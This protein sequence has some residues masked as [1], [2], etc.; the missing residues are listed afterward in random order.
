MAELTP[1]PAAATGRPAC[2]G[3]PCPSRGER[4][5]VAD[6]AM[7]FEAEPRPA[8]DA[9]LFQALLE[10]IAEVEAR[11]YRLL[12]RLGA[13]TLRSVRT[14]GGGAANPAWTA[15]RARL[16]QV[17]MPPAVS[18][19]PAYGTALLARRG[20]TAAMKPEHC[21]ELAAFSAAIGRDA[22]QVQAAG[23]NTS[24]KADGLLVGQGVG[25]VARRCAARRTSSCRSGWA[26]CWR[27]S[28]PVPPIRSPR[29]WRPSSTRRACARRSRPRCTRCCRT[30]RRAHPLGPDDRPGD[31]R[32][33][34]G[35]DRRAA[36]RPALALGALPKPGLPLTRAVADRLGT[37]RST[38]SCWAIMASSSVAHRWPRRQ[39]LLAEV[40][41]RLDAPSD[42][43][44]ADGAV[45]GRHG[46]LAR[47]APA[48]RTRQPMP[49][50]ST[51]G[52]WPGPRPARSTRT[53]S[54][55]WA[56][57]PPHC[58]PTVGGR[59][60]GG[61]VAWP[62]AVPGPRPRRAARGRDDRQR[63]RA[64]PVPGPGAGAGAGGRDAA[65]PHRRRRGR[66][67]GLGRREVP[68]KPGR[69]AMPARHH[70]PAPPAAPA[71]PTDDGPWL[72]PE[73]PAPRLLLFATPGLAGLEPA[74]AGGAVAAVVVD[75]R[76]LAQADVDA[77]IAACRRSPPPGWGAA[78]PPW[79]SCRGRRRASRRSRPR[80]RRPHAARP[81]PAD[82]RLLRP[83]AARRH[84]CG[85][86]RRRL[87]DVRRPA[88]HARAR[89]RAGRAR[90]PGGASCSCCL[91]PPAA[92]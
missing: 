59:R 72:D 67:A 65:L 24:L 50:P 18:L 84:G 16:L 80:G 23:G 64:G 37:G 66:A 11:A 30:G 92:A 21:A 10:G 40:E 54:S 47:A 44:P 62:Q 56:R 88:R 83:V 8:D 77:A 14:V 2:I 39:A 7:T 91:A 43:A 71:E 17:P 70:E 13:P 53:T 52:G 15:I 60:D 51:R 90:L 79:P 57:R 82:R 33:R 87:C 20:V 5:P 75:P 68:A 6:P 89:R 61:P 22:E 55:S 42:G 86:G 34:R 74:L 46:N 85:R 9:L 45:P 78:M 25:P 38:C 1:L 81:R 27:G 28:T 29:R 49:W 69:G 73:E 4:F 12:A 58:P 3:I 48:R 41:R 26:P 76:A 35:P 31:P 36:G 63:R 19:E 32:R